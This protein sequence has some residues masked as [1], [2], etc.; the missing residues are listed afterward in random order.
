MVQTQTMV[1]QNFFLL[2]NINVVQIEI[3]S[4]EQ[5]DSQLWYQERKIRLTASSF[6]QICKMR[7]NTSCKNSVYNI[8]YANNVQAKSLQYGKDMEIAARKKAEETMNFTVK[9]CGL[10]IDTEFPYLAASPDG[11]IGEDS[12]IEIKCPFSARNTTSAIDAVN[13]K[14]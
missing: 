11:L 12:V 14:L 13:N 4:R 10:F 2:E 9:P 6:G 3:D 5:T 8:L 1:W 7:P